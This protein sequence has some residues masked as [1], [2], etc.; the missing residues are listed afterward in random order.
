[1]DDWEDYEA[2]LL[3]VACSG[4]NR[5]G[6]LLFRDLQRQ[7]AIYE[8]VKGFFLLEGSFVCVFIL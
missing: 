7:F 1:M 6:N 3:N 2:P 8:S 5:S 4:S